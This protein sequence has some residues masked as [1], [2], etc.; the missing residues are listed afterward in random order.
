MSDDVK[1]NSEQAVKSNSESTV[2]TEPKQI[3]KRFSGLKPFTKGQSGN[4]KGR[5]PGTVSITAEIKKKM[6]EIFPEPLTEIT[7]DQGKKIIQAKKTYLEKT[8]EI[9]FE[10]AL[11]D[12]DTRVLTQMWAYMDGHPKATIDIGADKSSLD[13]LTDFF[14]LMAAPKKIKNVSV[15]V[16]EPTVPP[17]V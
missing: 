9:I 6:L 7:D 15:K 5:P 2:Q 17:S 1:P 13:D 14:R 10:T 16:I 12:K 8:I 11:K 4:P 3:P